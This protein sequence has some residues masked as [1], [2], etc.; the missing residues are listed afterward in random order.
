MDRTPLVALTGATVMLFTTRQSVEDALRGIELIR[1]GA[2]VANGSRKMRGSL[3]ARSQSFY[4]RML[5]K[6]FRW[7]VIRVLGLPRS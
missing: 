4:R 7:V 6:F 3:I 1:H 5:S 2:D